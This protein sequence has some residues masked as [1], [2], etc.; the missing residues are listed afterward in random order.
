MHLL[1]FLFLTSAFTPLD[2]S[3]SA[4]SAILM[5]GETG[6]VLWEKSSLEP[7]YPASITKILTALMA[8]ESKGESL[9]E[10]V[11]APRECLGSITPA[12]KVRAGYKHPSHWIEVASSH[13]GLKVGEELSWETLFHAVMLESANDASNVMAHYVAGDIP[14]FVEGMNIRAAQL[15]CQ[16]THFTNPH[17]LH[18][19]DHVT[20]AYDMALMT[21][22]ALKHPLFRKLTKTARWKKG[23]TN[24]QEGTIWLQHN[25][26]VVPGKKFYYPKAIGVKTGGTTAA[27]ATLV[28]A[29]EW[30]GRELIAVVMGCA[31]FPAAYADVISLF[32]AAFNESKV[33]QCL[34]RRG[35][36]AYTLPIPGRRKPLSTCTRED[37]VIEYRPSIHPDHHLFVSWWAV[38]PPIQPG[39]QIGEVQALSGAGELLTSVPL[40][41]ERGVREGG[42]S[43]TG[44]GVAV[45]SCALL[46]I[47][48]ALFQKRRKKR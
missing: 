39:E 28:G 24:K 21:R 47:G 7:T 14:T 16:K 25:Q 42:S 8:I 13:V 46:F 1:L 2:L 40:L 37:L 23:A 10:M 30:E 9:E 45:A 19:P 38:E 36:Q 31:S 33:Q 26:L 34:L 48:L 18:H 43:E 15:G 6:Q 5:E 17:G 44:K 27:K 41:A 12:E 29:A 35:S 22:E 11:V 32:E 20:C 4:K 3:V